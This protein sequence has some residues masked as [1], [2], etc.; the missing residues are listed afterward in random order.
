MPAD[1][2][3]IIIVA[4]H[5]SN[6]DFMLGVAVR[7]ILRFK[8]KYLAKMELFR[9][10]FGGLF[11]ALGGVPVDRSTHTNLVDA[12]ADMFNRREEFIVAIAPE[13]TRKYVPKWKSGFYYIA[14]KAKIPI[15]MC[16]FNYE[17]KVVYIAEPFFPSGD[18]KNDMEF[19]FNYFRD[20]KGKYPKELPAE[21]L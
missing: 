6:W 19:I 7:S 8:A 20:K 21:M 2:K 5:T 14:L 15:V 13:G 17:K 9:F 3:F 16:S 10:P 11:R 1:K 12:V 18:K 4:P